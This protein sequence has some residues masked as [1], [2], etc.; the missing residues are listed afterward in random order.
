M[1]KN[2][3]ILLVTLAIYSF[4]FYEQTAGL[5]Y[6]LF[7]I[8]LIS[9]LLIRDKQLLRSRSWCM[10]GLGSL[11]SACCIAWYGN[12]LS[13]TANI[14]S[15]S[16]LAGLSIDTRSSII[17][18]MIYSFLSPLHIVPDAIKRLRNKSQEASEKRSGRFIL[19][20]V[21]ILITLIF[22]FIYRSS[23]PIFHA[24]TEQLNLD[25]ISISWL[26]FIFGGFILLYSFFHPKKILSLSYFD[27]TTS[28]NIHPEFISS[29]SFFG[30][31]ISLSDENFSGNLLFALLNILLLVVNSLN[32][33]FMFISQTLPPNVTYSEFVHEG[34]GALIFSILIAIGIILYYFRGGLNFYKQNTTIKLLAYLWIIQNAFMLVSTVLRNNLYIEEYGLTEKRIGVYIYLLLT[35]IGLITTFVKVSA[36]KSNMYLFRAN[37]WLFYAVLILSCFFNW[38]LIITNY[39][40]YNAKE[41]D[42][43]YLLKLKD[44]NLPELYTLDNDATG[45]RIYNA[46]VMDSNKP[47]LFY[48]TPFE[49][50]LSRKLFHFLKHYHMA[51]WQ[52]KYYTQSCVYDELLELNRNGKITTIDMS[53]YNSDDIELFY[54]F[55]GI[56]QMNLQSTRI[57]DIKQLS[58]FPQL[59]NLDLSNNNLTDING[60]ESLQGLEILGLDNNN[61]TDYSPLYTLKNLKRLRIPHIPQHDWEQLQLHLP[62]TFIENY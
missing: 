60:I 57:T 3:W 35:L 55:N 34:T 51:E 61:I 2:D 45:S 23:N 29:F 27:Q 33:D 14:V 58:H 32:F 36:V 11:L 21:P 10:A 38:S 47:G 4:L 5:N 59:K 56:T 13:V 12:S 50:Q 20:F 62:D 37:T 41:L 44:T 15:L 46:G 7:N 49:D 24:F 6:L 8:C 19:I 43:E 52:S 9:A 16:I 54:L 39:N 48:P 40:I 22:F 31:N 28:N 26:F 42:T 17:F 30:K 1:K 18:S 53:G 25:F